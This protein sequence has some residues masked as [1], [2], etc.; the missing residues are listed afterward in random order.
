MSGRLRQRGRP[1]PDNDIWIAA[2]ALQ[3]SLVSRDTRLAFQRSGRT[4]NC[5]LVRH[6]SALPETYK[7]QFLRHHLR[8]DISVRIIAEYIRLFANHQ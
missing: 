5:E 4:P 2:S 6:D 3:H 1:I 7:G 8:K